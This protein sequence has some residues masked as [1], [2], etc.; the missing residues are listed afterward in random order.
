MAAGARRGQ[1]WVPHAQAGVPAAGGQRAALGQ[2]LHASYAA[3][4]RTQHQLRPREEVV[5]GATDVLL[6]TRHRLLGEQV[7]CECQ[8][9]QARLRTRPSR[10]P[11]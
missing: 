2:P 8:Q 9:Q 5:P 6:M 3:F 11:T 1:A 7:C 4:V 10:P